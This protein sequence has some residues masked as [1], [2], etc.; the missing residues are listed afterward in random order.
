VLSNSFSSLLLKGCIFSLI[1]QPG[2]CVS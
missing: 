1:W 2:A